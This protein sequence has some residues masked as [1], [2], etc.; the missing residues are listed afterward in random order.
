M[1]TFRTAGSMC[2]TP[3]SSS[4]VLAPLRYPESYHDCGFF[5]PGIVPPIMY[6]CMNCWSNIHQLGTAGLNSLRASIFRQ[7][8]TYEPASFLYRRPVSSLPTHC[9]LPQSTCPLAL[10]TFHSV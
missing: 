9:V 5:E 4:S 1:K 7:N 3:A 6:F 10:D 8:S 2:L